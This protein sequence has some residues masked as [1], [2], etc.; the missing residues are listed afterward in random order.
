MQGDKGVSDAAHP[1][2]GSRAKAKGLSA[3]SLPLISIPRRAHMSDS[4]A[5]A[6]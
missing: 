3:S 6:W 1:P 2:E 4:P 5:I